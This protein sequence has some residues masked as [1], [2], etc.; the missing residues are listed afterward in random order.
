MAPLRPSFPR[1][2]NAHTRCDYHAKNPDHPMKNCIAFKYKVKDL[3]NDGKLKFEDLEGPAKVEDLFRAK[4]EMTR[5]EKKTV[6]EANF[7]KAAM[8]KEKVPI[9]KVRRSE[10]GFSS[11]TKRSKE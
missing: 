5:Q 11:T 10:V 8:P 9:A 2:Y 3:I 4:V 1:W 6:K 7:G